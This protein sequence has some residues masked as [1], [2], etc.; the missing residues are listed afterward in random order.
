MSGINIL[1]VTKIDTI[2]IIQITIVVKNQIS[3]AI[4][5]ISAFLYFFIL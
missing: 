1:D 5:E 3:I 2:I 4:Y